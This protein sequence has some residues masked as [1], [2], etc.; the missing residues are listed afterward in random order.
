MWGTSDARWR[1]QGEALFGP[2]ELAKRAS[3][4]DHPLRPIQKIVDEALGAIDGGNRE[5]VR[6]VRRPS[7]LPEKLSW[8]LLLQA[9]YSVLCS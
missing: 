6:Q 5:V 9:F 2:F 8:A 3:A 7:I 1:C 4:I